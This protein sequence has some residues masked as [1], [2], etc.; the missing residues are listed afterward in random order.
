MPADFEV[1]GA[2]DFLKLSKALKNA[3]EKELR[4]DLHKGLR[5]AVKPLLP[6]AGAA[7]AAGM[8]DRLKGR[9]AKTKQVV[10]VKTGR[11]PGVS[12]GVQ[13]G[14]RGSGGMGASNA[15]LANTQGVI[16]HPLFGDRDHWYS[17]KVPRARRWF[18]DYY[19]AHARDALPGMEQALQT[20]ADEIVK[21]AK[22]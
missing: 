19:T 12:V 11:D 8:P 15:R 21:K 17:T 13:Y 9:A 14:K 2:G 4:K 22:R 7:F 16:R 18:D 20:I 1:R 6:G 3:G 5:E 10:K